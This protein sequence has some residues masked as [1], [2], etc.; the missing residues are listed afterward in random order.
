MPS[1][2]RPETPRRSR[3]LLSRRT[4]GAHDKKTTRQQKEG[5]HHV[6]VRMVMERAKKCVC[7]NSGAHTRCPRGP[8]SVDNGQ[9]GDRKKKKM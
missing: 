4:F 3:R 5:S 6:L 1:L 7:D 8:T 9:K 2:M